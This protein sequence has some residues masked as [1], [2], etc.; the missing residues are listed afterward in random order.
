MEKQLLG[1]NFIDNGLKN[2]IERYPGLRSRYIEGVTEELE[3]IP[4]AKKYGRNQIMR[5]VNDQAAL[6][7]KNKVI[8][9]AFLEMCK[10]IVPESELAEA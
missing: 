9:R 7:H 8:K 6:N 1:G 3:K 5:V 4:G 2:L 10:G